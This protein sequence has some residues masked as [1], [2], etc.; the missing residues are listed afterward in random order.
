MR[1]FL[2]SG[3]EEDAT[4]DDRSRV[5]ELI[6][7][8]PANTALAEAAKA[9]IGKSH[10]E[11]VQFLA[12]PDYPGRVTADR[13]AVS[14][15]I[16]TGGPA[17]VTAAKAALRGTAQDVYQFLRAGK[18]TSAATD[19]RVAIANIS[20]AGGPE[21]QASAKVALAGPTAMADKFLAVEQHRAQ[22]RDEQTAAHVAT[23]ESLVAAASQSANL[24]AQDAALAAEKAAR[25]NGAA[26]DAE[27]YKTQAANSAKAAQTYANQA[28]TAAASA[29]KSADAAAASAQT[30]EAAAADS[31]AA[32]ADAERS[33]DQ[34]TSSA[35]S[36]RSSADAA[37]A[38]AAQAHASAIAAGKSA[39]EA[40]AIA[41]EAVEVATV[42]LIQSW[43]TSDPNPTVPADSDTE[44]SGTPVE[45]RQMPES[46]G[47][48]DS[49]VAQI[50]LDL[51]GIFDPTG[52]TDGASGVI[53]LANGDWLGAGLSAV[54]IIPYAGD[55]FA[56][57][58][59]IAKD[60][61]GFAWLAKRAHNPEFLKNLA[62]NIE[63]AGLARANRALGAMDTLLKEAAEFYANNPGARKAVQKLSLPTQ[64]PI[65]FV[66][67]KGW[68][69]AS[70]RRENRGYVDAYGYQWRWHDG[71]QE[72]DV[73]LKSGKGSLDLSARTRG[74]QTSR[75]EAESPTDDS[76]MTAVGG[77]P[78]HV[79]SARGEG[80]AA[81]RAAGDAQPGTRH[82]ERRRN[83]ASVCL[84]RRRD[85]RRWG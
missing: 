26:N 15:L 8:D 6:S 39:A 23:V 66:P 76:R 59:K 19:D 33:A 9:V 68:N 25:A 24:A 40:V 67:P 80:P 51:I 75:R 1:A 48:S 3:R 41:L 65:V 17:T 22:L 77:R 16:A 52:A 42:R 45:T 78:I 28:A 34:A 63:Y 61:K 30:A 56:K 36:A 5:L 38:S 32:A 81:D 43:L 18:E 35:A 83:S 72:W 82:R 27:K 2:T 69:P 12:Y 37:Y 73:Q 62:F 55:A 21:V 20:A 11:I 54:S 14:K 29:K 57:G 79:R 71:Q 60:L 31:K 53:S 58:P 74:T 70:P 4:Q 47:M 13:V 49:Q 10:A 85:G 64:G 46:P 44:T 7:Q 84:A 50:V